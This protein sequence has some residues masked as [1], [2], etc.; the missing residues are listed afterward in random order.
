[1]TPKLRELLLRKHLIPKQLRRVPQQAR[2]PLLLRS[3]MMM[4]KL[5]S[6]KRNV[7]NVRLKK[8]PKRGPGLRTLIKE[9]THIC[10]CGSRSRLILFGSC[11]I[12]DDLMIVQTLLLSLAL[13]P[14]ALM[15]FISH[16]S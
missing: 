2:E 7:K 4:K 6:R 5:R 15:I 1:L 14:Q 11:L 9:I 8:R 3:S 13:S 16:A 10:T 12:R